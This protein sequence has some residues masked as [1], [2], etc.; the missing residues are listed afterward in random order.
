MGR[1]D[2]VADAY[3]GQVHVDMHV[4]ELANPHRLPGQVRITQL[5]L[6]DRQGRPTTRVATGEQVTFRLHYDA[7]EPVRNPVFSFAVHTTEGLLVT[8]PNTKEARVPVE[9]IEGSGHVDL[10]VDRLMLLLGSYDLTAECAD[11]TITHS[12]DR[13][14]RALRFDVS[15]GM[16]HETFGGLIS[17]DGTWSVD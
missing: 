7:V 16:P 11:D 8:G 10:D 5:E 6:L 13:L 9:K 15:P 12:F 2:Q 1:A 3:L 14:H 4:D 17:L